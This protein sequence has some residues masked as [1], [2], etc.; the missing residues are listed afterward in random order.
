MSDFSQLIDICSAAVADGAG[1]SIDVSQYSKIFLQLGSAASGGASSLVVNFVGSAS[2]S[3]P[4]FASARSVSN[5]F[6]Y[7][8]VIDLQDGA[9]IDGDTGITFAGEDFR[10]LEI[11]VGG[12]HWINAVISSY[13]SGALTLKVLGKTY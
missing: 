3:A 13:A 7:I 1:T 4:A 12:L 10:N 6:E 8:D 9:S 11:N 2:N 5:N